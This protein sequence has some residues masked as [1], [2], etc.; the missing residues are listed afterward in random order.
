[1]RILGAYAGIRPVGLHSAMRLYPAYGESLLMKLLAPQRFKSVGHLIH[2]ASELRVSIDGIV[3]EVRPGTSDLAMLVGVNE[4]LVG[5]W[6]DVRPGDIV[7]DVG[8]H[9]GRYTLRGARQASRVI[10]VEPDPRNFS[11]LERN[12]GL[13]GFSNVVAFNL[14][15]SNS[16]ES[17]PFYIARSG[18]TD[19]SSL[20]ANWAENL[21]VTS[22]TTPVK[23][24][25]D[26]LDNIVSNLALPLITWLK[27]DVEG[28][29]VAVLEGSLDSLAKTEHLILELQEKNYR[30]CEAICERA[31]LKLWSVERISGPRIS[32]RNCLFVRATKK[33]IP[34]Q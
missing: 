4:P 5:D 1:M 28:H 20:S 31:G 16:K 14:A 15:L 3:A 30:V 11:V 34:A 32:Y 19:L 6:F 22:D 2:G 13:N 21:G 8:A 9:I 27:I 33:P 10:A 24:D 18:D 26:T 17:L 7:V 25:C 23:V 29:E 12:I